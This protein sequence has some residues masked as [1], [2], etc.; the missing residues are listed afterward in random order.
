VTCFKVKATVS[1]NLFGRFYSVMYISYW[2]F[3]KVLLVGVNSKLLECY[4][5]LIH[6]AFVLAGMLEQICM[7]GG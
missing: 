2:C 1:V 4:T 3:G 7:S 6:I 5:G